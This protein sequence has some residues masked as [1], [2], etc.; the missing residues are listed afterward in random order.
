MMIFRKVV[1]VLAQSLVSYLCSVDNSFAQKVEP[2]LIVKSQDPL[3]PKP[4]QISLG[5]LRIGHT[6]IFLLSAVITAICSAIPW[7]TNSRINFLLNEFSNLAQKVVGSLGGRIVFMLWLIAFAAF[8]ITIFVYLRKL[9]SNFVRLLKKKFSEIQNIKPLKWAI[10]IMF[11]AR[12]LFLYIFVMDNYRLQDFAF[13]WFVSI[14][15]VVGSFLWWMHR[16]RSGYT[17][18][19]IT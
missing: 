7:L 18:P 10:V 3:S 13:W 19:N 2:F 5:V 8:W 11:W 4:A 17:A 12:K 16:Q 15:V 1:A 6:V 9:Y 14:G